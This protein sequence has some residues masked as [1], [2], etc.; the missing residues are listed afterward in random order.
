[1]KIY[2]Q[3]AFDGKFEELEKLVAKQVISLD[4]L[5]E[6]AFQLFKTWIES[7]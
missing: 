6:E 4:D 3:L 2:N 5:S 7:P 1:M